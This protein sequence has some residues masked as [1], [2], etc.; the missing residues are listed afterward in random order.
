MG[1]GDVGPHNLEADRFGS[2]V[3]KGLVAAL[4]RGE[5]HLDLS[6]RRGR[7]TRIKQSCLSAAPHRPPPGDSKSQGGAVGSVGLDSLPKLELASDK[8]GGGKALKSSRSARA[9]VNQAPA[10]AANSAHAASTV[11]ATSGTGTG[12]S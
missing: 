11:A 6:R 8:A 5:E 2:E 12:E 9:S 7:G 4:R 1:S 3:R 10:N